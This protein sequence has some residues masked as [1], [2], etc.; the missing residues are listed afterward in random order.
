VTLAHDAPLLTPESW[1]G[2]WV[3]TRS[4]PKQSGH[5]P[6]VDVSTW[7]RV[8]DID[9]FQGGIRTTCGYGPRGGFRWPAGGLRLEVARPLEYGILPGAVCPRCKAWPA[10]SDPRRRYDEGEL[11]V[12]DVLLDDPEVIGRRIGQPA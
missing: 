12:E 1:A 3:R 7:H 11:V 5:P 10:S 9:G 4:G 6:M 8:R 2:L